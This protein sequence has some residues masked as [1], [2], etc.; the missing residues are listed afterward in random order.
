MSTRMAHLEGWLDR[1]GYLSAGGSLHR[2]VRQVPVDHRYGVEVRE[3]LRRQGDIHADAVFDVEGV[4]TVCFYDDAG[5]DLESS[6]QLEKIREKIWNQNLAS[7]IL[8]VRGDTLIP[9]PVQQVKESKE[10]RKSAALSLGQA[11]AEGH[12]SAS[13]IRS[14][15][16]QLRTPKWFRVDHRVDKILLQRLGAVVNGL[17]P[18][19]KDAG[20]G[21]IAQRRNHLQRREAQL[22]VGQMMF[23]LYL[24]HR[25]IVSD[26]YHQ[27]FNVAPLH[28][29]IRAQDA[30]S[31]LKLLGLLKRHFNGDFLEQ[32]DG[33]E[34]AWERLEPWAFDLLNRFLNRED[35]EGGQAEF[36]PYDF[37]YIPVELLSGIYESFLGD[38]R[39]AAAAYYTP[40][41]LANLVVQEAFRGSADPLKE[42]VYDGA[43]GSGILLTTAY[44]KMLGVAEARAGRDLSLRER[45]VLLERS[46]FGSDISEMACR[47]TAFSLYLSLFERLAP[48]DI[49]TQAIDNQVK[50]PHLKDKNLL[51][52]PQGDFFSP[53]NHLAQCTYTLFLNNPP[54][55]QPAGDARTQADNWAEEKQYERP[56]RQLAADFANRAVSCL[57]PQSGRLCMILPLTLFLGT[58]SDRYIRNWFKAVRPIRVINFGDLQQMLFESGS[59]GC[60]VALATP[61]MKDA[62]VP[63]DE[64][65]EYCVPKAEA[66]L[67]IGRLTLSSG[68]RHVLQTQDIQD[69]HMQLVTLMWGNSF[70]VSLIAR[71]GLRGTLDDLA[72]DN[73]SGWV[74]C[75]GF[76]ELDNSRDPAS[77]EQVAYLRSIPH[78][79]VKDLKYD[80]AVL[81]RGAA[82]P[83]PREM[84]D[85]TPY[86][87]ELKELFGRPRLL[88]PDGFDSNRVL[89]AVYTDDVAS[90]TVSVNAIAGPKKDPDITKFLAVMLRSS[91]GSYFMVMHG[92]QL[93]A[94]RNKISLIDVRRFPFA[95]PERHEHPK[96]AREIVAQVAVLLKPLFT[97]TEDRQESAYQELRPKLDDLVF[98]YYQISALE[99]DLVLETVREI[100]PAIRP[101]GLKKVF[102]QTR[103]RASTADVQR[104]AARLE[105]QLE[106]WKQV[107]GGRTNVR[108][109]AFTSSLQGCGP[110]GVVRLSVGTRKSPPAAV[111]A[112]DRAV[113]AAIQALSRSEIAPMQLADGFYFSPDQIYWVGHDI[114]LVRPLVPRLWL[115]RTAVRDAY[116]IV[117][118]VQQPQASNHAAAA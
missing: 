28:E 25:K 109:E 113:T 27:K 68:D 19:E 34:D 24:E 40:P 103:R 72:K 46:I 100:I 89:R 12:Y 118:E 82:G 49:V 75:K 94:D 14:G 38:E 112:N 45:I 8:V 70:D 55:K 58:T 66:S 47:V 44:R 17:A 105:A 23:V 31:I 48:A 16:F 60:I 110:L 93:L 15:A 108:V 13:D 95:P 3:L 116:R 64:T 18:I 36:W 71:L 98:R 86:T 37:S 54:W 88:F 10:A 22:L 51:G 32:D 33:S 80:C 77:K 96:Q 102:E 74:A 104:Y 57:D 91:L 92:F 26:P 99:R 63:I 73:D 2:D 52:G 50:L 62:E 30:K 56:L 79:A 20:S 6:G 7:V 4:P 59:H 90:F 67:A 61:R 107:L 87:D 101:R 111:Q 29:L 69:D 78:L 84:K 97:M 85:F 21:R 1:L 41:H 76:H 5:G 9:F 117:R 11:S 65:F 114:Y 42:T 106:H 39:K 43:C 35:L 81:R 115:D 53:D 83:L